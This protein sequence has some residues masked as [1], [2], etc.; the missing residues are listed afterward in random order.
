M[1][2]FIILYHLK[3]YI[4]LV[5]DMDQFTREIVFSIEEVRNVSDINNG[6]LRLNPKRGG[7]KTIDNYNEILKEKMKS[8]TGGIANL[9]GKEGFKASGKTNKVAYLF[10]QHG[11]KHTVWYDTTTHI[12]GN[13]LTFKWQIECDICAGIQILNDF[14]EVVQ[15]N[16]QED[17]TA[18]TDQVVDH[19][20]NNYE[21]CI[22]EIKANFDELIA[23]IDQ[24]CKEKEDPLKEICDNKILYSMQS[25]DCMMGTIGQYE[26]EYQPPLIEQEQNDPL[27]Q[28]HQPVQQNEVLSEQ[29][30]PNNNINQQSDVT[31]PVINAPQSIQSAERVA[32]QVAASTA[33]TPL[34]RQPKRTPKVL[35]SII[36][37]NQK[38][39]KRAKKI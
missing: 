34:R 7:N 6:I 24:K 36:T 21:K 22:K 28:Q 38:H 39:N 23:R 37:D 26:P 20:D 8:G 16:H 19:I 5:P 32:A 11:K 17:R 33:N 14:E 18:P 3:F 12:I 15:D 10:C 2:Q 35:A 13:S 27:I 1:L 30:N 9:S 29:Q 4:Y 31:T 25:H